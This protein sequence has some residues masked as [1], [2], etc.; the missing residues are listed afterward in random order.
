MTFSTNNFG[1]SNSMMASNLYRM[2]GALVAAG[3]L[4]VALATVASAN[5]LVAEPAAGN[6]E[7][8]EILPMPDDNAPLTMQ[9]G[10]EP[11]SLEAGL[12][13]ETFGEPWPNLSGAESTEVAGK[14][15]VSLDYDSPLKTVEASQSVAEALVKENASIAA[16]PAPDSTAAAEPKK[17][18]V[19]LRAQAST[20]G[21]FGVDAGYMFSDRFHARLG[22]DAGG[23]GYNTTNSGVDYDANASLSNIHLLGDYFPFGG[24]LRLTGG[25]IFQNNRL[26]GNAKTSSNGTVTLDGQTYTLGAAGQVSNIAAEASYSSGVAPYLGIGY[27]TPISPGLSFNAE[28]GFMFPGSPSVRLTPTVS[29]LVPQ[30]TADQII[31]QTRQQE[32]TTNRDIAGFTV[33]PVLSIGLSYAF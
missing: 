12:P 2:S 7:S 30:A 18:G 16:A 26:T 22:F 29:P 13:A 9:T 19:G 28:L 14:S 15:V 23:F 1:V 17:W 4:V 25:L 5:N 31:Q 3:C 10:M 11:D 6:L 8:T 21:L 24:G 27:G 20:L 33:Y 32:A